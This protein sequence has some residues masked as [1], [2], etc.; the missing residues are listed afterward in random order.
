MWVQKRDISHLKNELSN[1]HNGKKKK[2]TIYK[3]TDKY[4][5]KVSIYDTVKKVDEETFTKGKNT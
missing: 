1:I 2:S 5:N 3:Q 4:G